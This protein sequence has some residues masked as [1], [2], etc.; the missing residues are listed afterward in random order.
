MLEELSKDLDILSCQILC[1]KLNS[2]KDLLQ[3][4]KARGKRDNVDICTNGNIV[5]LPK[6]GEAVFVGDL[7]GD[8]EALVSI[9][10]QSG[11]FEAMKKRKNFFLVF[12]GDY[13]DRGRK[14][15]ETINGVINLKL[16]YPR[17]IVLLKGN[18]EELSIAERYGT[19]DVFAK[20]YG[21]DDGKSLLCSYCH[22]MSALP[23][24]VITANG[25]VGVHGG[26]P[27]QD[28][29]SLEVLNTEQGE[30]LVWQMTWSDPT[31]NV[32]GRQWNFRGDSVTA[33]GES[34]F[35]TFMKIVP[36]TLMVRSHEYF[37]E[38]VRLLFHDRLAT[39]FSNGS[40]RSRSSYYGHRVKRPVF[41]KVKLGDKKDRFQ[42]SDFIEVLY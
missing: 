39:I 27:N 2:L 22:V 23:A 9:V 29:N 31:Q 34:A 8:F 37:P 13:G 10:G 30:S 19:Y 7:H 15:I 1:S 25:I 20:E 32:S 12:L 17:N 11:F 42:A 41:L 6:S 5:Y 18:H 3:T 26:V 21:D 33:F 38:G 28:I 35:D 4:E 24:V 40:E 16:A 14:T 36:A